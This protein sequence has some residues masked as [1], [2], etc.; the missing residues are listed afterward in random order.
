MN[1]RQFAGARWWKFD[2][3]THTPAST[4]FKDRDEMTHESWLKAF[5]EKGIDCVAI[6]DHNSGEWIDILK[7]RV[8]GIEEKTP[9]VSTA[10]SVP[11]RGDFSTWQRAYISDI[12]K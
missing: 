4:D 1:E 5:M 11:G 9:L 12:W 6:T 8:K 10:V 3:H 7:Q 2:F